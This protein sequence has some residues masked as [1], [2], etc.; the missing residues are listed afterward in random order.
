MD[1]L[2]AALRRTKSK[3]QAAALIATWRTRPA[4]AKQLPLAIREEMTGPANDTLTPEQHAA[5]GRAAIQA[6]EAATG[7]KVGVR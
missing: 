5:A 2:C 1:A 4:R 3:A 7:G 6:I